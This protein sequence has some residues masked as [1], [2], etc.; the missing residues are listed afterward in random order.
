MNKEIFN[1]IDKK[2]LDVVSESIENIGE[3]DLVLPLTN[4]QYGK[5]NI[6]AI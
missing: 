5:I 2:K 4:T 6:I 1:L 3:Y